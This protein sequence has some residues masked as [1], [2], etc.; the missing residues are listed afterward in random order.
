MEDLSVKE[1]NWTTTRRIRFG[2]NA[3]EVQGFQA[4]L[5]YITQKLQ[6]QVAVV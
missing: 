5:W 2:T 4:I 3:R 1:A 6:K